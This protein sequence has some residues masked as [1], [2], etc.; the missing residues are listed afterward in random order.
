MCGIAGIAAADNNRHVSREVLECMCQR[1]VHRGPDDEG[2]YCERNIG[3]AMRR[4]KVVDLEG[5][6]QPM[7]NEDG[8][9]WIVFNGE[10]YNHHEL[11]A[12]LIRRGHRFRTQADTE[13][14]VHLYED[15]GENLFR[16]LRGMYAFAIWD[17]RDDSLLL[18]RDRLGK[19][20][21][22]YAHTADSLV[23]ASEIAPLFCT[24]I[25]SSIDPVAIDEYLTY[26]FVPHPRTIYKSV[27]KLPPASYAIYRDG[28]L[29]I[30]RYWS[31]RY[32]H[33]DKRRPTADLVEEL[34]GTLRE[35]VSL[36][37]LADVPVG[38]F[39]SGGLDS[40]LITAMMQQ[41]ST[42]PVRTFSIGFD[43]TAYNELTFAREV[44]LALDTEH[45][46]H[47]VSY[48]VTNIVP[49]LIEHFGEPFADSSAIPTFHLSRVT[50]EKVTVA[51]SG[52]GG[53]E[54]FGGYRRYQARTW[55]DLAGHLPSLGGINL[56]QTLFGGIREP[57]TY[58]GAST[59]K[60][61]KRFAEYS[62]AVA[63]APNTSWAFFLPEKRKICC[64]RN[65]LPMY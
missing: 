31:V 51:L 37:M 61:I 8:S 34:D 53:D 16:Q 17:S 7:S 59:I 4:L 55:A 54:I 21:L 28:K 48:D 46:E 30:E 40:S 3:L 23:F 1:M 36:R 62:T 63:E 42:K 44:A 49:Q 11:R 18:A 10:I 65:N 64:I 52:D 27:R 57:S 60:K 25:D 39:L 47:L 12:D 9:I 13:T 24:D 26:L 22:F 14:I 29:T 45:E 33:V 58:F 5:G 15:E 6:S 43:D 19:K 56:L 41:S 20:P 50:R 35:A 38:A 2:I 32:D